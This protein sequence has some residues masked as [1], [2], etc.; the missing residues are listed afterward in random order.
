MRMRKRVI[1]IVAGIVVVL[2]I[3]GYFV[4]NAVVKSKLESALQSLPPALNFH[5]SSLDANLFGRSFS[6][7]G[8]QAYGMRIDR[9]SANGIGYLTFA[10]SHRLIIDQLTVEGCEADP[11]SLRELQ[12]KMS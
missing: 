8:V 7:A 11:D 5:Y 6:V 3:A 4:G 1:G 9:V 10:R 2:L 12:K